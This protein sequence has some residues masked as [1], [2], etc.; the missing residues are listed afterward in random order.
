MTIFKIGRPGIIATG[1]AI[2]PETWR[3]VQSGDELWF[4]V[5]PGA[6]G[7]N[8]GMV[9]W[10]LIRGDRVLRFG[11]G[12]E[13]INNTQFVF[14]FPL[15]HTRDQFND[16]EIQEKLSDILWTVQVL[17][18]SV[19]NLPTELVE[20]KPLIED[21]GFPGTRFAILRFLDPRTS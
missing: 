18:S 9:N 11:Y 20:A 15:P 21:W 3:A 8:L 14:G 6:E 16:E 4:T 7:T 1:N 12:D 10:H 17:L 13:P 5:S 2:N 19:T